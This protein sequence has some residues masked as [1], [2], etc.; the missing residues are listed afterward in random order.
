[1]NIKSKVLFITGASRGIG[2]AIA[3]RAA[4]E[5]ALVAI[6]SKTHTPHPSLPGTIY[7]TADEIKRLGG[8]CLP[9][10]VD[11]RD[12]MQIQEAVKATVKAFGGIDILINNASAISLLDT[13]NLPSKQY[14]LMHEINVR[15]TF[16]CSQAC[17]PHLKK[18]QNPHILN[19]SPPLNMKSSV[20][21]DHVGYSVS[22]YGMSLCVLG[23]AEEF[24]RDGIAVNALW[25]EVI[26]NTSA[27]KAIFSD[28]LALMEIQKQS[29]HPAIVVDAAL[30]I[31]S[32]PSRKY[33][34][35]FLTDEQ[36]LREAGVTDF[37]KYAVAPG[38][39]L[40]RD[41]FLD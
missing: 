15:G 27:L 10:I 35:R 14:D 39:K 13:Q 5:G 31:I 21:K 29:R 20:L 30:H 6:A 34:G 7:E 38:N 12:E 18:A 24:S 32:Q 11:I 40:Q 3:L 26:I 23:L 33:T 36:A 22:K 16:Q 25:P 28:P 8:K 17:I 37:S 9:L 2:K 41:F 19:M 4:E 1:M